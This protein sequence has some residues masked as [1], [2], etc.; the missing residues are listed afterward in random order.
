MMSMEKEIE[1]LI[2]SGNFEDARLQL[3][4]NQMTL[5]KRFYYANLGYVET[6]YMNYEQALMLYNK[7]LEIDNQ[8]A[9]VYS[10]I[11][12]VL[13]IK[14]SFNKALKHLEKAKELGRN[15]SF[16]LG[17]FGNS[18]MGLS[19]F[20]EALYFYED[21]LML[22]TN[23]PWFLMKIGMCLARLGKYEDAI[24]NL[25]KAKLFVQD[26]E[27]T[28]IDFELAYAY[29]NLNMW[30][31]SYEILKELEVKYADEFNG[32]DYFECAR[33]CFYGSDNERDAIR[34][35]DKAVSMGVNHTGVHDLYGDVYSYLNDQENAKK[36]F[37]ICLDYFEKAYEK[38]NADEYVLDRM[39]GLCKKLK[40][41]KDAYEYTLKEIKL[42]ANSF[43]VYYRMGD[44]L[45]ELDRYEE[46]IEYMK[47][48][49]EMKED[50]YAYSF[51]GFNYYRI[52]KFNEAQEA[53]LKAEELGREDAWLIGL[54][55]YNYSHIGYRN[56]DNKANQKA[57]DY[58]YRAKEMKNNEITHYDVQIGWVL[59][60]MDKDEECIEVLEGAL[61]KFSD[62]G[63][64]L[65][66]LAC[67]YTSLKQYEKGLKFFKLAEEVGGFGWDDT[68]RD[69]YEKCEK[70]VNK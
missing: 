4:N 35:L 14:G 22:D 43:Q 26:G 25:K 45:C 47:K 6:F 1:E 39:A 59:N 34:L 66:N 64:L 36:H 61:D 30:K 41:Y 13:N 18:Y 37:E 24:S 5:D 67:S 33:S 42:G 38:H 55:G 31:E 9:W 27:L 53:L 32:D 21:A 57:L 68:A 48:A 10:Q 23:N 8:D 16:L 15:D 20:Q 11:G 58:L 69:L 65:V 12:Y 2:T 56:K 29:K 54:I 51:I 44:I 60:N 63:L 7:Y 28:G 46:S 3:I 40:R 49:L 17:E 62:N 50:V 19:E 52:D 70:E